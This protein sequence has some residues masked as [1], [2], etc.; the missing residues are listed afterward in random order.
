M[1]CV[2]KEL[3]DKD[4]D[5]PV[6]SLFLNVLNTSNRNALTEKKILQGKMP[7]ALLRKLES[8]SEDFSELEADK[9]WILVCVACFDQALRTV[10]K[11]VWFLR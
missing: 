9:L 5:R 1:S 11:G 6:F 3:L 4:P 7:T 8:D 10:G 2:L